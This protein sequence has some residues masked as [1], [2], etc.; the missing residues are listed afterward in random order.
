MLQPKPRKSRPEAKQ[1]ADRERPVEV[2]VTAKPTRRRFTAEYKISILEQADACTKPGELG[3]LLRREG[4]YSS[5]LSTWREAR[6]QGQLDAL[7]PKKRGRK[8][9]EVDPRDARIAE[10]ERELERER[11]RSTR[12]EAIVELQKKMAALLGTLRN[13]GQDET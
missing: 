8:S 13:E 7:R 6:A 10:L 1:T 12:A 3:A 5:H 4:L 9:K 11:A 2:Q